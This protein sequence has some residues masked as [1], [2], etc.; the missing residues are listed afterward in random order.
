MILK[1]ILSSFIVSEFWQFKIIKNSKLDLINLD[2]STFH[3]HKLCIIDFSSFFF[4]KSI[5]VGSS[6]TSARGVVWLRQC[7]SGFVRW[8]VFIQCLARCYISVLITVNHVIALA[9]LSVSTLESLW[10]VEK[11]S[12]SDQFSKISHSI[13]LSQRSS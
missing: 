13:H 12:F 3:T 6:L 7:R 5:F 9:T 8:V 11:S 10:K 1:E 4:L 2:L